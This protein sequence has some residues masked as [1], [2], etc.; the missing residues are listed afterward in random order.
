MRTSEIEIRVRVSV[1]SFGVS[2][3][4]R[5]RAVSHRT[6]QYIRG[7]QGLRVYSTCLCH[8]NLV[9]GRDI[10]TALL[11]GRPNALSSHTLFVYGLQWSHVLGSEVACSLDILSR[12]LTKLRPSC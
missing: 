10:G 2:V 6:E 12:L 4:V 7:S 8:Q 3:R 11:M 9:V 1:S 5:V